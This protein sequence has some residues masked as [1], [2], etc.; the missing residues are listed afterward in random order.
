MSIPTI[1]IIN[2]AAAGALSTI[3]AA[4][5]LAPVRHLA[6]SHG[7]GAVRRNRAEQRR[8]TPALRPA[9]NPS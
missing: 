2:I 6:P 7:R 5:M 8:R 9:R 3:L 1:M 4:V